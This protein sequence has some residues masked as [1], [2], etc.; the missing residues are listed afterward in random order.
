MRD[1][2]KGRP[3]GEPQTEG[4]GRRLAGHIRKGSS[5]AAQRGRTQLLHP[6]QWRGLET[7]Y[8]KFALTYRSAGALH[9]VL[10]WSVTI[11]ESELG[12]TP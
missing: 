9:A 2:R 1:P 5:R 10:I 12:D 8:D 3:A 11:E 6:K 7:R 4:E